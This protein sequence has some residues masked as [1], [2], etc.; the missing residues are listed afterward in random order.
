M[1]TKIL[2]VDDEKDIVEFLQYNLIHEGFEVIT[3]YNGME[4]LKKLSEKPDLVILDIMM[5]QLN[6]YDVCK[7]L[8]SLPEFRQT[9][10]I[11]LTAKSSEVDEIRGLEI[12]ANDFIQK[13]I[14]PKKLIAR[15]NSNLRKDIKKSE[16]KSFPAHIKIGLLYIDRNK[17]L[18]NI[19]GAEKIFP[20]KE[21]E[22]LYYLANNPGKVFDRDT[23][24]KDVWG[25]DVYVVDR[26]VD[27]H[28]R[29][30]REKLRKHANLIETVKGVGYKFKSVEKSKA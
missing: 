23:L 7:K 3:A 5:P 21:F 14:S 17:Y 29:K 22:L 2:L 25:L 8:R 6:G 27:V 9:P 20:R 11:F 1:K 28:I 30:I 18:V 13:P 4:A 12:G 26:T 19:D 15:V 16:E 24:L 10:V